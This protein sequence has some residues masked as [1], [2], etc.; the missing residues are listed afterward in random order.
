MNIKFIAGISS[1]LNNKWFYII[2]RS[3]E[4]NTINK[5]KEIRESKLCC[6]LLAKVNPLNP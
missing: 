2:N 3:N 1:F 4:A 6:K 5:K